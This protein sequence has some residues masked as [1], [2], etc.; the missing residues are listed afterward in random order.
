MILHQTV[1]CI[2]AVIILQDLFVCDWSDAVI[3]KLEPSTI[4]LRL[5]QGKVVTAVKVTRMN[6]DAMKLIDERGGSIR[7]I[8]KEF[9]E[10][11]GEWEFMSVVDLLVSWCA[12]LKVH[13]SKRILLDIVF[14]SPKLK[15]QHRREISENH[16]L[17][18]RLQPE[19]FSLVF[20]VPIKC[21]YRYVISE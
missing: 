1:G 8:V 6:E 15:M 19:T 18:G 2:A 20:V 12:T 17:L 5:Y 14:E 9:G 3:I 13:L 4:L 11:D 16:T 7:G 21:L 10:I